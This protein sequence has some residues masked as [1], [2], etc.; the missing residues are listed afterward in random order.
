MSMDSV[1]A[2]WK[3]VDS[4]GELSHAFHSE[5][6]EKVSS[7]APIVAFAQEHGFEFSEEE[8]LQAAK[9]IT[10]SN[11]QGELADDQLEKVAGGMNMYVS[12][13]SNPYIPPPGSTGADYSAA[14]APPPPPPDDQVF[15]NTTIRY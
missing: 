2:F 3:E 15:Y 7:G 1:A 12:T 5:I 13:V 11:T 6:P 10:Q 14:L 4:D 8:L 9:E